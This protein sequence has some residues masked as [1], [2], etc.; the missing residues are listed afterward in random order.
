M[1]IGIPKY[2]SLKTNKRKGGKVSPQV[3]GQPSVENI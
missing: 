3:I 2:L 1:N